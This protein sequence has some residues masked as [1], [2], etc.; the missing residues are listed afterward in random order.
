MERGPM[1]L[2]GAIVAIGLGPS[3]WLGAQFGQTAVV[4]TT[5]RSGVEAPA[6]KVAG[7]AGAAP[8]ALD[9][10]AGTDPVTEFIPL[11][12]TPSARRSTSSAR[13]VDAEPPSPT[14]TPS[15]ASP[16]P[17]PSTAPSSP[18]IEWTTAPTAPPTDDKTDE[19]T[20]PTTLSP[21]DQQ[22]TTDGGEASAP[23]V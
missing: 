8:E 20:S 6:G 13:T 18:P 14:A 22:G 16:T 23:A 19:P 4:P 15:Q 12:V 7:G 5:P 17:A 1:M 11:S 2:F 21:T 9:V 10:D 3:M